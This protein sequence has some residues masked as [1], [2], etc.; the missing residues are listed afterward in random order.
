ML[1]LALPANVLDAFH[2][3]CPK[4]D[5]KEWVD[6]VWSVDEVASIAQQI[7]DELCSGHQV[8]KLC[9][10]PPSKCDVPFESICLFNRNCLY[11]H[12]LKY[13]IK[14]GDVGAILDIIKHIMLAFRGTGKTPKYADTLFSLM[15]RLKQMDPKVW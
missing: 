1:T 13:A 11:L 15:V 9:Q 6:S 4:D 14:H 12:Q 8:E 2:I 5:L 3:Y 7:L 10:Q